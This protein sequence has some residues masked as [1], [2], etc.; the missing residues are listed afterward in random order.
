MD[1][2]GLAI[3]FGFSVFGLRF[4][5]LGGGLLCAFLSCPRVFCV[6]G[7]HSGDFF[8]CIFRV[9]GFRVKG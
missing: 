6:C 5:F 7:A 4:R 9:S 2:F 3:G 1:F 8:L